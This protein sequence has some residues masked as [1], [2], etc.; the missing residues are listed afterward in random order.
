MNVRRNETMIMLTCRVRYAYVVV[1][2]VDCTILYF[3]VRAHHI[4]LRG[5]DVMCVGIHTCLR[6]IG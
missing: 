3:T 2:G 1:A 5:K 4:C 6:S